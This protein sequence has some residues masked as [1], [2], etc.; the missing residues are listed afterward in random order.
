MKLPLNQLMAP[1]NMPKF[2]RI[3][4]FLMTFNL[5]DLFFL[6]MNLA[7]ISGQYFNGGVK[8]MTVLI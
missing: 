4:R 5:T 6:G 8:L 1:I 2:K 3:L 7:G